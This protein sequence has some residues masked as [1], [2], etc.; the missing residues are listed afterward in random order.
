MNPGIWFLTGTDTE[1][2]KT[3]A[4]CQLLVRARTSGCAPWVSKPSPRAWMKRGSMK[5]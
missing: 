5:T 3:H 4:A 2:G 1:I